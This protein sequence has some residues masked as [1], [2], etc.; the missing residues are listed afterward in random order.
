MNENLIKIGKIVRT[1]GLK[2][3]VKVYPLTDCLEQF[4][5]LDYVTISING[6]F[7]RYALRK[8]V[9]HKG[10]P[11]LKLEGIDT[12]EKA[13]VLVGGEIYIEREQRSKLPPDNFF[14][15]QISGSKVVSVSGTD[16]GVLKDILHLTSSD[17]L[18]IDRQG[19]EVLIP[20]VKSL[21]PSVDA[22]RRTIKVV[23]M[24]SLWEDDSSLPI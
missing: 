6:S 4:T 21:V 13:S 22:N 24:P 10:T 11:L 14:L 15:D 3:Q 18:V 5:Q 20:F 9:I 1:W 16:V 12:P 17:V 8:A 19:K 23:D 2:G 7:N